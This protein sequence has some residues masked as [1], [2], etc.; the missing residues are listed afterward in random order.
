MIKI[1]A[2]LLFVML[3]WGFNVS[4]IKVLVT[5]M[6]PIILTALRIFLAGVAVLVASV[7]MKIF[8]WPNRKELGLILYISIFN[9]MLHHI[10]IALGLQST[11]GVNTGLILGTG[12]LFTMILAVILLGSR[13]SKLRIIGFLLGFIG[14]AV[15]SLS[16]VNGFNGV[17][18]GDLFIL[19]G[20]VTQAF[21]F[22]LISKLHADFDPRLLTGYMLVIGSVA[23]FITSLL[24]ESNIGQITRLFS[25]KLGLVFLFS[26]LLCTAFGHMVYNYAIKKVGPAEAAIFINFN[27][28]F[29]VVGSVIFLQEAVTYYHGLGFVLIL[30]GVLMGTGTVEYLWTE[31][32]KKGYQS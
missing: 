11:L 26:S 31:R 17:S 4:A 25:W 2:L 24:L 18:L 32:R 16:G 12:P 14:V 3:L 22:I 28:V 6:D 5:S 9:V 15:T 20:V 1:Y 8:R 30:T 23:I 29:A 21:S 13:V 27:T 10:S 7:F 19:T